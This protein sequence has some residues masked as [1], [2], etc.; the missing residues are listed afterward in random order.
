M[1][2]IDDVECKRLTDHEIQLLQFRASAF[3]MLDGLQACLKAV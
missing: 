1:N 2:H 3:S